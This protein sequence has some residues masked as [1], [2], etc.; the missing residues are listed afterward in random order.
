MSYLDFELEI[1]LS[2]N[3]QSYPVAVLH[4]PAGEARETIDL[5]FE[6]IE[7]DLHSLHNVLSSNTRR[8]KNDLSKQV[9]VKRLGKTLF[10]Q[11]FK[12]EI[13]HLYYESL[14]EAEFEKKGLRI[15]LRILPPELVAIPWEYLYDVRGRYL[16]L[17]PDT[18]LVRYLELPR[19][20]DRPLAVTPPLRILGM[21]ASPIDLPPLDIEEEKA[22]L[23]KALEKLDAQGLIEI[24]WLEGQS[25]RAL[26]R[27]MR[28][29]KW[30]IFHF[31]GHGGFDNE[32]NEGYLALPNERGRT[33]PF[34][35]SKLAS[36]LSACSTLRL[37]LLNACEGARGN[38]Q[39]LFSSSAATLVRGGI[40]AVLAM[41]NSITDQA[42]IEFAR[43]FY[44][45]LADQLPVD[46]AVTEAR[47]AISFSSSHTI[48]WGTPVLYMR[49]LDGK[50]F[51]IRNQEQSSRSNDDKHISVPTIEPLQS[52]PQSQLD[53]LLSKLTNAISGSDLDRIIELAEQILKLQP[54]H[55]Q[56]Q[57]KLT[58]A[59]R[60]RGMRFHKLKQ[61]QKAL[62]DY[63]RVIKLDPSVINC[64]YLRAQIYKRLNR[65]DEAQQDIEKA[66]E[67][68][69]SAAKKELLADKPYESALLA[70][71]ENRIDEA[72]YAF[73][74]AILL[75]RSHLDAY[76]NLGALL[77]MS[78]Q[79]DLAERVLM[80]ALKIDDKHAKSYFRLGLVYNSSGQNEKAI[81]MLQRY[82]DFALPDE[83]TQKAQVKTLLQ[84]LLQEKS[85]YNST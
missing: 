58:S 17:S 48:E 37:A 47:R 39:S 56:V 25:W 16:S 41:Q 30:H 8:Q 2:N 85:N 53:K 71:Q 45:A 65:K 21:I 52:L 66:A 78:G 84:S 70:W 38:H 40:P 4:S 49:S 20:G 13:G 33:E 31:I 23:E 83:Q 77:E 11:L 72:V 74:Q 62:I 14:H 55:K 9:L 76:H 57:H 35:A 10:T 5:S 43:T 12:G 34:Y 73:K 44:E 81:K 60:S 22:Q 79:H 29:E 63:N 75:N 64:Y 19:S 28:R 42:A 15:R 18:P 36:L 24:T 61:Y 67:R 1:G 69:H 6:T 82:L 7:K 3:Q 32:R 26:Q 59:Y 54:H 51:R 68:G 50:L 46:G 27:A 80:D